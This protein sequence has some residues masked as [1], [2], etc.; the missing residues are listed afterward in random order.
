[1]HITIYHV[2]TTLQSVRN[3]GLLWQI[4]NHHWTLMLLD[5][6]K[7]TRLYVAKLQTKRNM[8]LQLGTS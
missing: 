5:M 7:F 1:M 4:F 3:I 2:K 6:V 8:K